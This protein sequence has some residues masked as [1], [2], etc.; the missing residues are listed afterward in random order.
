MLSF[1][2]IH[3]HRLST[4]ISIGHVRS[5]RPRPAMLN[6]IFQDPQLAPTEGLHLH[7]VSF[8]NTYLCATTPCNKPR[9]FAILA[10]SILSFP[11]AC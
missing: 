8:R 9:A 2:K 1:F 6:A 11:D 10:R 4:S 5:R 7:H 3:Q